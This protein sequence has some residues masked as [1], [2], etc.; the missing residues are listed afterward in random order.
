MLGASVAGYL[1]E[2]VAGRG[3]M[4]VVYRARQIALDRTVALKLIAPELARDE[5]FRAR[6]ARESRIAASLDHP[7]VIPV[8]EAGEDGERLFIAMRFVDGTDLGR[9]LHEHGPLEPRAAAELV[10]QAASALD[11]AHARGLVHRD[12]KPANLLVGGDP[13]RPHVYLTDFGLARRDGTST[14]LTTTGQW[15]GTPDYAAPEQIDGDDVSARTD[16]YAL[17]CVLFAALTGMP[18]FGDRPRMAK[19]AA[20]LHDT[21][22]TLRGVRPGL[23][24]AFEPVVARALAKRPEERYAS[25]GELGA[26][27][28]AAAGGSAGA[29]RTVA[30]RRLGRRRAGRGAAG[31]AAGGAGG[32][33]RRSALTARLVGS[34]RSRR[35]LPLVAA[36]AVLALAALVAGLLGAFDSSSPPRGRAPTVARR[37]VPARPPGPPAADPA[38]DT[39]R[40][41]TSACMQGGARVVPPI[42]GASCAVRGLGGKW[43]RVDADGESPLFACVPGASPPAGSPGPATVPDLGGARLDFAEHLL[44]RLGVHHG[45]SGGGTFGI[46]DRGNWTVCTTT[47]P[48]GAPLAAGRS[49]KLFV[50]RSC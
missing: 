36:G 13:A 33:A 41:S 4:G 21:P 5:A 37:T 38:R 8:Y 9:M 32:A 50:D 12:V 30:T 29:G 14:A 25:A 6:F 19:A 45:T 18:P 2:A 42:E 27:A 31:G 10:A 24:L 40:C 43:S 17:G 49:I 7:N 16:V 22:P 28:L 39:V 23:P 34:E 26:A 44:D 46:I 47:P 3:G 35:G 48:S 20:H 11:A 15:M 1:I